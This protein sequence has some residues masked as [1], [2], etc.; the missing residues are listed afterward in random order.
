MNKDVIK[1]IQNRV[2][3]L[4][5]SGFC[6]RTGILLKDSC[7]E[8][9]RLVAEW[10]RE[11]DDSCQVMIV[12][13]VRVRNSEECHDIVM[14]LA[15][16]GEIYSIDPTIWQFFPKA[17]SI[18]VCITQDLDEAL[19]KVEARYGGTWSVS[20]ENPRLSKGEKEK[21][22]AIIKKNNVFPFEKNLLQHEI[23]LIF[24]VEVGENF[25]LI[26]KEDH[27]EFISIRIQDLKNYTILPVSLK[28]GVLEWLEN[29]TI[30]FKSL[31]F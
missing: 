29:K 27:L 30:F 18:V 26:S 17:E 10:V 23:N 8:V 22:L 6:S 31:L 20:E 16:D 19:K 21:Y 4:V 3:E 2:L 5:P 12:K 14:V 25:T 24:K 15:L 13:G 28:E 11:L 7:S 1:T 9:S